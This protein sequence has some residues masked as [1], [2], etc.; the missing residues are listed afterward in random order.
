MPDGGAGPAAA[1]TPIWSRTVLGLAALYNLIWGGWVVLDPLTGFRWAGL[2]AP[3]YPMVWQCVGM[4]VAAYGVGYAIAA[5]DP[6]R[7]WPIVLVGLIGKVLGPIGFVHAASSGSLPWSVGW[8]ILANDVVWWVPFGLILLR[9]SA[10]S[11]GPGPDE[12]SLAELMDASLTQN[13]ESLAA[14]SKRNPLLVVFLRHFGCTFCRE[15]LADL[16]ARREEI[17][18]A[19]TRIVLVHM[20]EDDAEAARLFS[21]YELE[22]VDRISDPGKAL[23]RA[24]GL[25]RGRMGQLFSANVM[26]RGLKAAL[27]DGH[28]MGW[29]NQDTFQMPGTF[30]LQEGEIVRAHRHRDAADRP[31]YEALAACEAVNRRMKGDLEAAARIQQALLPVELPELQGIGFAWAFEPC[32]EL[33]GDTLNVIRLDEEHVG[34]YVLDVSGHGVASSL[35][36]VT[37]NHLL[38][39]ERSR[40]LLFRR[41][42]GD[43]AGYEVASPAAVVEKL[44]RQFPMDPD[45]GQYFTLLY[46]VLNTQTKTLRYVMAGHPPAIH[47]AKDEEPVQLPGAGLPIGLMPDAEYAE[48]EILLGE[49]DRV[50]LYSDGLFETPGDDDEEFGME[51]VM[52]HLDS[53]RDEPLKKGLDD[54]VGSVSWWGRDSIHRDDISVLALEIRAPAA[55]NELRAE[56]GAPGIPV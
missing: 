42:T 39:P 12:A 10:S 21:R 55:E 26:R 30:L 27:G 19:G 51:R 28:G 46:G 49:G 29:S 38:L 43:A 54:L 1:E 11:T 6:D 20:A 2:T 44:N 25:K 41:K 40:S 50:Y 33:A 22:D 45:T 35:L 31:D 7:H 56:T 5:R 13:G 3:T 15:A 9:A 48:H 36:S 23:Y 32:D 24:F 16:S 8:M 52:S 17:E 47:V 14:I 18:E 37:L 53:V 4:S 34:L